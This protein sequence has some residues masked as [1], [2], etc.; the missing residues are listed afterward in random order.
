MAGS[1]SSQRLYYSS[2]LLAAFLSYGLALGLYGPTL[3]PVRA[4]LDVPLATM[5]VFFTVRAGVSVL[6]CLIVGTLF[7]LHRVRAFSGLFAATML[8][9]F[10]AC[11][12][13][14][15]MRYYFNVFFE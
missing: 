2:C 9:V 8:A 1:F 11:W 10:A 7:T 4:Q 6:G 5:S 3:L 13:I 14:P 15:E 12:G